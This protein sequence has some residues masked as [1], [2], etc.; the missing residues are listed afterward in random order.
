MTTTLE[1]TTTDGPMGVH[2]A[3]PV[4]PPR[5]GVVVVQ[6]AFGLTPH[7]ASIV[8]RLAAAGYVAAAPHLFHRTG[9][10]VIP[11]GDFDQVKPHTEALRTESLDG[12]VDA[13]LDFLHGE[14][15]GDGHVAIV[16]FCLG[17][18]VALATAARLSLGAAATFY[19]GGIHE[20]RFGYPPLRELAP[21]LATPWIGFYGDEDQGIP[22]GQV[23]ERR[24]G[25]RGGD[26]RP[27]LSR[28]RPR[29]Q[30]RR[31]GRLPPGCGRRRLGTDARLVRR[32]PERFA[33]HLSGFAG[34]V[35]RRP[36]SPPGHPSGSPAT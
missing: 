25:S 26:R 6:E 5:G 20:G 12:D 32:P 2:V 24:G 29:L 1:L 36:G 27:S 4:D 22:V 8:D 33:G 18:T 7:I 14:G 11:Y 3:R 21:R 35:R 16:G 28:R 31:P 34:A 19:G 10:P 13:A 17:G 23:E 30:L 15:V 9:D